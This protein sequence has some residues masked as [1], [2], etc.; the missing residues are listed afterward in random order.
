MLCL[1]DLAS[2]GRT[3]VCSIHQPGSAIYAL[4][5]R[6][7]LM[8]EGKCAFFGAG[9]EVLPHFEGLGLPCPALFNPADHLLAISSIDH[10]SPEVEEECKQRM[11]KIVE[12]VPKI[13]APRAPSAKAHDGMRPGTQAGYGE[14]FSLLLR[15]CFHDSA[16]DKFKHAI[17]CFN[18]VLISC[19]VLA[20]YKDATDAGVAD[21]IVMNVFALMFF[22]TV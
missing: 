20:I 4:F 3:V 12:N 8:A 9:N 17:A 13:V 14:Q 22:I 18:A 10:S 2:T 7:V 6:V 1:K 11:A 5:D 19:I 16:R 15:R 21:V